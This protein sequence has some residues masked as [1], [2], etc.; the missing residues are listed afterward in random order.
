MRYG[1][2]SNMS[3]KYI[4][5]FLE[6]E[7][8]EDSKVFGYL[9]CNKDE[10]LILRSM[11]HSF[12]HGN[13]ESTAFEILRNINGCENP[14]EMLHL[15][16]LFKNLLSLG[17]IRTIGGELSTIE[18]VNSAFFLSG[19]FLRLFD[20]IGAHV[21][22][23]KVVPYANGLDYLNDQ[24]LVLDIMHDILLLR[25]ESYNSPLLAQNIEKLSSVENRIRKRLSMTKDSI[26]VET[27]FDEYKLDRNEK[28]IFL[29]ILK[30]E[31][32]PSESERRDFNYLMNLISKNNEEKIK[33]R[34]LLDD[35]S[36]L[37]EN[38][39]LECDVM[40]G[41]NRSFYIAD[42]ILKKIANRTTKRASRKINIQALIDDQDI[43]EFLE[44]KYKLDDVVLNKD[45]R[46]LLDSLLKQMD[47][48]VLSH[49][50]AWGIR[51]KNKDIESKI[52]FYGAAGTGKTMTA[53]ALAKSL[54]K[55]V[56]S[57]DCSKILS[58][59]VGESEKNVRKIFDTYNDIRVKS[60]Q[61]PIML[62]DEADQFLSTRSLYTSGADKMHNQMQ[63]IFLEQIEK[64]DGIL[65][66]TT[67]L[68]ETIDS[69]FSRRFNYKIEFKKPNH[70]ERKQ[71]WSKMLPKNAPYDN[72]FNIDV[73]SEY[74]LT[75]GQ[76][77]I[78]IKNVA[79]YVASLSKPLFT[80]DVFINE[81]KR[82]MSSN[83][84]GSREMGFNI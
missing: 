35:D 76:I 17:W 2:E 42:S 84:D 68:L 80:T 34:C 66:A 46:G 63:N 19:D 65:I 72:G 41:G 73:L 20:S 18:L 8:I 55:Q 62:L 39:L 78:I 43:F 40:F 27:I 54:K 71:L 38:G 4:L 9:K 30:E 64:F 49:L 31:Y 1:L 5:E 36:R 15:M 33:N 70:Q 81:I 23:D 83:F 10:A 29:S 59:Y 44:P 12:I 53:L 11:L 45:T 24:F 7:N 47:A 56:L 69:A 74:V 22:T 13:S 61:T 50:R 79:F 16:D 82:E 58:M 25:K 52:I 51:D 77:S 14:M 6:N 48:K 3:A 32:S 60:K 67:N 57:F 28:I 26:V 75:G 37:L 21:K